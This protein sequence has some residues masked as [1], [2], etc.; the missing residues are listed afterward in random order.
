M[1]DENLIKAVAKKYDLLVKCEHKSRT[2]SS[3]TVFLDGKDIC[4][5]STFR[6]GWVQV[7]T[8]VTVD[9]YITDKPIIGFGDKH[10]MRNEK[11]FLKSIQYLVPTYNKLKVVVTQIQKE[12]KVETKLNDLEKDF[13]ND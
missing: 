12:V 8:Q 6:E 9:W 10:S 3:Y 4:Y 7:C 13:K 2:N 5:Y 1:I 11:E